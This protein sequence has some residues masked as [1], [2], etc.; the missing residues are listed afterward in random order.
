MKLGSVLA[1][2]WSLF[3]VWPVFADEE[4]R[5]MGKHE[6]GHGTLNIAIEGTKVAM[7]LEV[8]GSDI[9]GFE[10]AAETEEQKAAVKAGKSNLE[11]AIALF[12]LSPAAK[13]QLATASSTLSS[14]EHSGHG[15]ED[16]GHH[17][18]DHHEESHSEFHA[19]YAYTCQDTSKLESIAFGYFDVFKAAVELDVTVLTGTGSSVFKVNRDKTTIQIG[20]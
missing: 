12:T 4:R 8:P 18:H 17:S 6:H 1:A 20:G 9:V 2:A 5:Q 15:H 11:K 13:C 3:L 16:H 14:E 10:H 7:S 19:E